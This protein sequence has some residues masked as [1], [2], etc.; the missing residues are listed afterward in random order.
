MSGT[1]LALRCIAGGIGL[2]LGALVAIIVIQASKAKVDNDGCAVVLL[3]IGAY[4]AVFFAL[5]GRVPFSGG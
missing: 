4:I 5:M 3:A 2:G 1:D